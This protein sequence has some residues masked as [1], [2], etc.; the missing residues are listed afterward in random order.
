MHSRRQS[1]PR[2]SIISHPRPPRIS[3]QSL[4]NVQ[5]GAIHCDQANDGIDSSTAGM[6]RWHHRRLNDRP[7]QSPGADWLEWSAARR[8][9]VPPPRLFS[10]PLIH[11]SANRLLATSSSSTNEPRRFSAVCR[12]RARHV[13]TVAKC[14][15]ST[16]LCIYL[17]TPCVSK[18]RSKKNVFVIPST[19]LGR[20]W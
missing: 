14:L 20:L 13:I 9:D 4:L 3:Q 18:K 1:D 16:T 11:L 6:E 15:H 12:V 5:D 17:C 2:Q 8:D 7:T 19:K 10:A